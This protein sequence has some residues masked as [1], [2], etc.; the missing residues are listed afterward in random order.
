MHVAAA[1]GGGLEPGKFTRPEDKR[2]N[3]SSC[4]SLTIQSS[5]A[6]SSSLP[7][8]K[9]TFSSVITAPA[10]RQPPITKELLFGGGVGSVGLDDDEECLSPIYEHR[11]DFK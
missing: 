2:G 11:S 4:A 3:N 8:T 10:A 5:E 9:P 6:S 1:D 7:A